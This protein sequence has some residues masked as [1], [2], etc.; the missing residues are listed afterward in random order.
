MSDSVKNAY[1][2][3]V[4]KEGEKTPEYV[5]KYGDKMSELISSIE[6]REPFSYDFV[7]DP[8]YKSYRDRYISDGKRAA[9]EAA[10]NAAALTG[11]YGNS[12]GASASSEA[13]GRYMTN[14]SGLIPSLY[15]AALKRYDSDGKSLY[16]RL[17]LYKDLDACDYSRYRDSL[18]DR[19][20]ELDYLLKKYNSL[21]DDDYAA[22]KTALDKWNADRDYERK[23]YEYDTSAAYR[24]E[25]DAAEMEYKK[26]RDAADAALKEREL[27]LKAASASQSKSSSSTGSAT[28][29]DSSSSEVSLG[30]AAKKLVSAASQLTPSSAASQR[31]QLIESAKKAKKEGR[32]TNNEYKYIESLF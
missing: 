24:A 18:G 9:K 6:N 11:G 29:S 22:F 2:A 21:Y 13:M 12:Y 10:A 27:A 31:A 25:R 19:Q 30:E 8:L 5:S 16:D 20:S 26:Q 28:R 1:A 7:N 15:E 14:L 4:E 32:I 23:V 3:L 17:S